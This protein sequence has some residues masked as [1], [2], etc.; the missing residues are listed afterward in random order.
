VSD[1]DL[2]DRSSYLRS[3]NRISS[4]PLFRRTL[5]NRERRIPQVRE[6]GAPRPIACCGRGPT[7]VEADGRAFGR[8]SEGSLW[9]FGTDACLDTTEEAT[10]KPATDFD[11]LFWW[12]I[13]WLLVGG[14]RG[15][16]R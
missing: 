10:D 14:R 13:T 15:C 9:L 8:G 1:P 2:R 16:L 7:P 12:G 5:A 6:G 11:E 4:L 3:G